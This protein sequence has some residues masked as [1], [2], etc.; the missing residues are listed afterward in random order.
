MSHIEIKRVKGVEYASFV[1]K[2]SFM[3]KNYRISEHI[4]K[5]VPTLNKMGYMKR[6]LNRLSDKEFQLGFAP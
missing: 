6:N 3:G 5:N 4:G 1:K 2:F